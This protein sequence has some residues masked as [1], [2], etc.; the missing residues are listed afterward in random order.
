MRTACGKGGHC[1]WWPEQ[2]WKVLGCHSRQLSPLSFRQQEV[3]N[4]RGSER[5]TVLFKWDHYPRKMQD[6]FRHAFWEGWWAVQKKR[7][8]W[9]LLLYPPNLSTLLHNE[10]STASQ[11]LTQLSR[12]PRKIMLKCKFWLNRSEVGHKILHLSK[13]NVIYLFLIVL[14]LCRCTGFALVA[15]SGGCSLFAV[16]SGLLIVGTSR[17]VEHGL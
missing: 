7:V 2:D 17:V 6:E 5:T 12:I 8:G 1:P 9:K 4:S 10:F 15:S 3:L 13:N 14:G 16:L 11:S